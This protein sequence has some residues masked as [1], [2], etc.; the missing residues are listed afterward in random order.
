M[1]LLVVCVVKEYVKAMS[2]APSGSTSG[3]AARAVV[4]A[5]WL[6]NAYGEPT[7]A[8]VSSVRRRV[9]TTIA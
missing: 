4:C 6:M 8:P 5:V 7:G 3:S 2:S 9:T 1:S